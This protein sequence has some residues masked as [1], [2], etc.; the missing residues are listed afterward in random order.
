MNGSQSKYTPGS[1]PRNLS[2]TLRGVM[3]RI[4]WENKKKIVCA[5]RT[6]FSLMGASGIGKTQGLLEACAKA[7]ITVYYLSGTALNPSEINGIL[8]ALKNELG[9]EVA[10][11]V[12]LGAIPD[13]ARDGNGPCILLIDDYFKATEDMQAEVA[14]LMTAWKT[15]GGHELPDFCT[16]ILTGN[17]VGLDNSADKPAPSYVRR[18]YRHCEILEDPRDWCEWGIDHG[19]NLNVVGFIRYR[20]NA[21]MDPA[22]EVGQEACARTWTTAASNVDEWEEAMA[23]KVPTQDEWEDLLW[24]VSGF[25]GES[26][27]SNFVG[28]LR[29]KDQLPDLEAIRDGKI[30]HCPERHDFQVAWALCVALVN[31]FVVAKGKK[32]EKWGEGICRYILNARSPEG[33]ELDPE[34]AVTILRDCYRRDAK[35]LK[36]GAGDMWLDIA[37]KLKKG[38]RFKDEYEIP[39]I[40]GGE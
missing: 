17:R 28:F 14:L 5:A 13:K 1:V 18:R 25:V 35:T 29:V 7:K 4:A 26:H 9:E 10:S 39:I 40:E 36:A 11:W 20:P 19:V 8:V 15:A 16:V 32:R 24:A 27:A 37:R 30:T 23:D 31:R 21:W 2:K 22:G 38:E 33:H 12:R 6:V 34:W 3:S